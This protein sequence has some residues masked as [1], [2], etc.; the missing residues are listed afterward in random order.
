MWRKL[1]SNASRSVAQFGADQRGV[2]AIEFALIAGALCV[3]GMNAVDVAMYTYERM[4]VAEAAHSGAIAGWKTCD[5]QSLP[6]T[7]NCSGFSSAVSAGIQSTSLGNSVTLSSGSPSEGYYCVNSSNALEYVSDVNNK[8]SDCSSAGT[9]SLKPADYITVAVTY[10]FSPLFSD[11]SVA[12][13]FS[14]PIQSTALV[15]ME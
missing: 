15:R 13:L 8:P 14:S 7:Q 1:R 9:P 11:L 6:A 2:A 4:E 12:S 3:I 5:L 10:G